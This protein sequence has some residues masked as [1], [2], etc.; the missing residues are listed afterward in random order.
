MNKI[1]P[2]GKVL[3]PLT[4]R[5]ITKNGAMHLKLLKD[6]VQV[7][8][9]E[10]KCSNG[11]VLNTHTNRCIK[12][13]SQLYKIALK[14]GWIKEE[15]KVNQVVLTKPDPVCKKRNCKNNIKLM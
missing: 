12:I 7:E 8:K 3:N 4:N 1:C 11:K 10:K 6:G 2:E 14:N 5:C 13:G 9:I 15:N